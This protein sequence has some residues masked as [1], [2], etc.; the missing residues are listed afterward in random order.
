MKKF[1]LLIVFCFS[2]LFIQCNS[3]DNLM[4]EKRMTEQETA[5]INQLSN[6]LSLTLGL[7]LKYIVYDLNG[8][9]FV[10][11]TDVL[12]SLEEARGRFAEFKEWRFKNTS[13]ENQMG[14][15]YVM[16]PENSESVKIYVS[17][18][19][20]SEWRIAIN[21]AIENWN[22]VNTSI[23]IS[24]S[25]APTSSSINVSI[26]NGGVSDAIANANYPYKGLPGRTIRINSYY[27]NLSALKKVYAIT[28]E[29]GHAFGLSHTN[30]TESNSYLIPCTP[31]SDNDSIMFSTVTDWNDFSPYDIIAVSTLYPIAAGAKKIYRY[32]KN[33]Y[34]YYSTD[35]CEI[36]PGKDGYVLD[37]DAG[38]LYSAQIEGTVPLYRI[39]N[40]TTVK[41][42]RLSRFSTSSDDVIIGYLYPAEQPETVA[43]HYVLIQE[44][45]N[46]DPS[47]MFHYLYATDPYESIIQQIVGYGPKKKSL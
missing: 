39:L 22:S 41:D 8:G 9:T 46:G 23:N 26:Y 2:Q 6:F 13:K 28:H 3:D 36:I 38:Y 10:I 14:I 18:E 24:I 33:Q 43:I 19:V 20:P 47:Y 11:D 12:M 25:D 27:N 34:Y 17:P 44:F 7:D 21:K 40:G 45:L 32:K 4:E 15:F 35:P 1:L 30:Q 37:K 5:E 16:S 42:H 31:V 29:L